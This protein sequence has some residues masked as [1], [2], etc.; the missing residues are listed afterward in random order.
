MSMNKVDR[1]SMLLA[2]LLLGLTL[3]ATRSMV[4]TAQQAPDLIKQSRASAMSERQIR[5][6]FDAMAAATK[7]KDVDGIVKYMAPQDC[8][9]DDSTIRQGVSAAQSDTRRVPSV[10]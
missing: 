5:D 3:S 9:Q 8:H 6:I 4:A 1:V 10:S 2:S 7:Q